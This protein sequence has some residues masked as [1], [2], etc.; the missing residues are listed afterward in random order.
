MRR[1]DSLSKEISFPVRD[2]RGFA[3]IMALVLAILYFALIELLLI[4]STLA[5]RSARSVSDRIELQSLAED[6]AE[7]VAASFCGS[8]AGNIDVM[9][10]GARIRATASSVAG[11]FTI[12]SSAEKRGRKAHI[13]LEGFL[14]DCRTTIVLARYN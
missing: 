7:F 9:L 13:R 3:L 5:F 8:G 11:A 6:G 14:S 10:R 12:V 2:E 4:E 1:I